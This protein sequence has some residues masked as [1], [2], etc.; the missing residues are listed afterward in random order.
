[1]LGGTGN[2]IETAR[3]MTEIEQKVVQMILKLVV[4]N[5]REAWRQ[6]FDIEFAITATET[7]PHMIQVVSPNEMVVV[8][9]F[10]MRTQ[11]CTAKINL[12]F[13]TAV[14][15]A[16]HAAVYCCSAPSASVRTEP[17]AR[18]IASPRDDPCS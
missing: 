2:P 15:T 17:S 12:A 14:L 7:N 18:V 4:D 10:Q 13:P 5:L 16:V 9:A 1:M 11:D 3:A 8:F 6:I